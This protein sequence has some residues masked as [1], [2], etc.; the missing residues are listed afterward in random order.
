MVRKVQHIRAFE[1]LYNDIWTQK[2]T[3]CSIGA[4]LP[5]NVSNN[6]RQKFT[7]IGSS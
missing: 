6:D 4:I 3:M 5:S 1:V 7:K 2:G